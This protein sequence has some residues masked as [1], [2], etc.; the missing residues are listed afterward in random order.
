MILYHLYLH[1]HYHVILVNLDVLEI[2]IIIQTRIAILQGPTTTK[3]IYRRATRVANNTIY[4]KLLRRNIFFV[5]QWH[6]KSTVHSSVLIALKKKTILSVSI[7]CL[8]NRKMF[9]VCSSCSL[10]FSYFFDSCP[11]SYAYIL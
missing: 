1:T 10:F 5:E 11:S 4:D 3:Y 7:K 6:V 9:K 2:L 8:F